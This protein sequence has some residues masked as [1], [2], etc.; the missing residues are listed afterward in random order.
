MTVT[1]TRFLALQFI[2]NDNA[3]KQDEYV[4]TISKCITS[5]R[6]QEFESN[7][8]KWEYLKYQIKKEA[9]AYGKQR[10][11]ERREEK[12]KVE[13][14]YAIALSKRVP[15]EEEMQGKVTY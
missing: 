11:K 1:V 3:L 10:A 5:V 8:A 13:Q 15:E 2:Y 12:A 4:N 9:M 14:N 7:M 6:E